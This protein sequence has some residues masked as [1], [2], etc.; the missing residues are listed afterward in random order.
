M[1]TTKRSNLHLEA[2]EA[3]DV[4]SADPLPVLMVL[5]NRDWYYSQATVHSLTTAQQN[6]HTGT[7]V[8]RS[9]DSGSTWTLLSPQ[10]NGDQ[11]FSDYAQWR[12]RFG[13]GI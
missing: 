10:V 13:A 5:P 11:A 8:L 4:P 9:M 2:L 1:K 7:G 12:T 3:R 6:N